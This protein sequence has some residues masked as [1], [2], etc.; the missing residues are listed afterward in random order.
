MINTKDRYMS[1]EI[2]K[3]SGRF[4]NNI[5]QMVHA[6]WV[7]KKTRSRVVLKHHNQV[8]VV[9]LNKYLDFRPSIFKSKPPTKIVFKHFYSPKDFANISAPTSQEFHEVLSEYI[10][11]KLNKDLLPSEEDIKN[12]SDTTVIH[13][14]SGDV[15]DSSKTVHPDYGQP[16]LAYYKDCIKKEYWHH[17]LTKFLIVTEQDRKN[18]VINALLEWVANE[19]PSF[20]FKI[21]SGSFEEDVK[22]ILGSDTLVCGYSTFTWVLSLI[23]PKKRVYTVQQPQIKL[24]EQ[25]ESGDKGDESFPIKNL[26]IYKFD[27]YSPTI[28]W[29]NTPSQ[30]Q[31]MIECDASNLNCTDIVLDGSAIF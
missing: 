2:S 22:T 30:L 24:R 21:Q 1:I 14:R 15:F 23:C 6:I 17:N 5:I 18:P 16:P 7:G 8:N 9:S 12:L 11:P 20:D 26:F 27:N 3:Y 25:T 13:I 28:E 10:I 4:S 31:E 29:K 19:H